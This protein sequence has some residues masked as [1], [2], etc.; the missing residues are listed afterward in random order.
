MRNH[1][2]SMTERLIRTIKPEKRPQSLD[3][4]PD[5][6]HLA[7]GFIGGMGVMTLDGR[8]VWEEE[9]DDWLVGARV[10]PDGGLVAFG[11]LNL[12]VEIRN[13]DNGQLFDRFPMSGVYELDW[14]LDSKRLALF[15]WRD[16]KYFTASL[17]TK[18]VTEIDQGKSDLNGAWSPELDLVVIGDRGG[19]ITLMNSV[20]GK[21]K[22]WQGHKEKITNLIWIP[23]TQRF[24]SVSTDKIVKLWDC[25]SEEVHWEEYTNQRLWKVAV[26]SDGSLL[27]TGSTNGAVNLWSL[28]KKEKL[29]EL[30]TAESYI[31]DLRFS[32][33]NKTLASASEE[34][35]IHLW[36]VSDLLPKSK[37][38]SQNTALAD[39]AARQAATIGYRAPTLST[40]GAPRWVPDFPDADG[41]FLGSIFDLPGVVAVKLT[42]GYL[43]IHKGDNHKTI[44]CRNLR[45]NQKLWTKESENGESLY[46]LQVQPSGDLMAACYG[47]GV[48]ELRKIQTGELVTEAKHG[49]D[50]VYRVRWSPMG[51]RLASCSRDGTVFVWYSAL[52]VLNRFDFGAGDSS[53]GATTISWAPGRQW[54]A[55]ASKGLGCIWDLQ[56]SQKVLEVKDSRIRNTFDWHSDSRLAVLGHK[57]IGIWQL[58]A[59]KID[60]LNEE[61]ERLGINLLLSPDGRILAYDGNHH[62]HFREMSTG[63][64]LASFPKRRSGSNAWRMAWSHDGAFLVE[65]AREGEI[66]FWDTRH[67]VSNTQTVEAPEHTRKLSLASSSLASRHAALHRLGSTPPLSLQQQLTSLLSPRVDKTVAGLTDHP[68]LKRLAGLGLTKPAL[69]AVIAAILRQLPLDDWQPPPGATPAQLEQALRHALSGE[70]MPPQ[71]PP[72]PVAAIKAALDRWDDRFFF[73]INL[74][75]SERLA[76]EPGLLLRFLDAAPRLP[77]LN[78]LQ[79]QQLLCRLG[80]DDGRGGSARGVGG[81]RSGIRPRGDFHSLLPSQHALPEQVQ[82]IYHL[83]GELL[84]RA[85]T[86]TVPPKLRPTVILLDISPPTFGPVE[87]ITRSAAHIVA[88]SLMERNI[89]AVLV[90][91]EAVPIVLELR[92]TSDLIT[93]W[94]RRSPAPAAPDTALRTAYAAAYHLN[95]GAVDPIVLF[96]THAWFSSKTLGAEHNPRTLFAAYPN[97]TGRPPTH[98]GLTHQTVVHPNEPIL[99]ALH[100][101]MQP[102]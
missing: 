54:L 17:E 12:A 5:G 70:V 92:N 24:A 55:A 61:K 72:L 68:C 13:T 19:R 15:S 102:D 73:L 32:P 11:G 80:G 23:G 49:D 48:M 95:D 87:K 66:H 90:T 35:F 52:Q 44:Q 89:P 38:R 34:G 20:G 9:I 8:M 6:A 46:D 7:V 79:Q 91:T 100:Q 78:V 16:D 76:A 33:D 2:P 82:T 3:W 65:G 30:N 28:P 88:A 4:Q 94:T 99:P 97:Q 1:G 101:L 93:L 64:L 59:R 86:G 71:A 63:N 74:L 45:T 62:L 83:R 22:T 77:E 10:S 53:G 43:L 96:L 51:D 56:S 75:G 60:W 25:K 84:Y 42:S 18:Q 41:I 81:E 58:G 21:T 14:S 50:I 36:D 85:R 69:F 98:E 27:A 39:Y 40:V 31:R 26:T 47:N 57:Q 29:Y 67:L 37:P